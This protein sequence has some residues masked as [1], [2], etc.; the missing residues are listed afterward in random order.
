M[1]GRACSQPL[2]LLRRPL[3]AEVAARL[4]RMYNCFTKFS[5]GGA[6]AGQ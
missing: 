4:S 3:W 6:N 2:D 5:E 1:Y